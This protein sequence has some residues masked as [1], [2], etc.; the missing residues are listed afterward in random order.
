MRPNSSRLIRP[1]RMRSEE[2]PD[3]SAMIRI[4]SCSGLISR[5]K[6]CT[7]PPAV[8]LRPEGASGSASKR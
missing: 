6:N 4:A 5:E 7:T 8:V 1:F 3:A 2:T